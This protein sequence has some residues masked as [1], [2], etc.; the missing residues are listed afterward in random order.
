MAASDA[1]SAFDDSTCQD[2][3][4]VVTVLTVPPA[5]VDAKLFN[6]FNYLTG[7]RQCS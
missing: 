6:I 7:I 4:V 1:T 5:C 3:V 2:I